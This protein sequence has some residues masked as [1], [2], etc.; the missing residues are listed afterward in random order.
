MHRPNIGRKLRLGLI[1]AGALIAIKIAEYFVGVDINPGATPY[2]VV[3]A[4]IAAWAILNY[5]MHIS[6]LWSG[7]TELGEEITGPVQ[8]ED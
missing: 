6:E 1:V 3:L 8:K 2:L 4:L 5:F 7:V